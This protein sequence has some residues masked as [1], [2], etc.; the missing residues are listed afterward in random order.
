MNQVRAQTAVITM[1][2]TETR[3]EDGPYGHHRHYLKYATAE[4]V[5][6][7]FD[8]LYRGDSAGEPFYNRKARVEVDFETSEL[9][10][11]SDFIDGYRGPARFECDW[12]RKV[13]EARWT[14]NEEKRWAR[15]LT[16][17]GSYVPID[18]PMFFQPQSCDTDAVL[19]DT[20]VQDV[21]LGFLH[22]DDNKD[23]IETPVDLSVRIKV[24]VDAS[25]ITNNDTEGIPGD[26]RSP[27]L[28]LGSQD[29]GNTLP[30]TLA[31]DDGEV[32]DEDGYDLTHI[33]TVK[34]LSPSP[35]RGPSPFDLALG[36]MVD[37][38]GGQAYD[39]GEE[40]EE[41]SVG[42]FLEVPNAAKHSKRSSADMSD[43]S[44]TLSAMSIGEDP[45]SEGTIA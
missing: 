3:Q 41:G 24:I 4:P 9:F 22:D 5:I 26:A 17:A 42:D 38:P 12:D 25:V 32:N 7:E 28:S 14:E 21:C 6:V 8:G 36:E 40:G 34:G 33:E 20:T 44:G 39:S 1:N 19:Y 13:L 23:G 45:E 2:P 29:R 18:L 10:K 30:C 27:T 43:L 16:T 11:T 37:S 15:M 31:G 35:A